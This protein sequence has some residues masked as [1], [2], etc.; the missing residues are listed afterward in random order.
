[1]DT[2][3]VA[4]CQKLCFE[5]L[6]SLL[7][8]NRCDPEKNV[9]ILIPSRQLELLVNAYKHIRMPNGEPE[10]SRLKAAQRHVKSQDFVENWIKGVLLHFRL[11]FAALRLVGQKINLRNIQMCQR[12]EITRSFR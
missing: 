11:S 1:M 4:D 2:T 3:A 10:C 9:N 6:S 7:Q 5:D 12:H 8:G